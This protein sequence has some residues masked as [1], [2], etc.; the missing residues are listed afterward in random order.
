MVPDVPCPDSQTLHRFILGQTPEA[1]AQELERHLAQCSECLARAGALP[2]DD[3]LVQAMRAESGAFALADDLDPALVRKLAE[4][5]QQILLASDEDTCDDHPSAAP[6]PRPKT[7]PLPNAPREV[8]EE[9]AEFLAPP[10][11]AGELGRLGSYGIVKVLGIGGMGVVCQALQERPRRVV[12]LKIFHGGPRASRERLARFRAETEIVAQLQHANI[13]PVYE[14]GEQDGRPFF[15]MELLEGGSL[16]EQLEVRPLATQAAAQ[17]VETLARAA[18]HAHEHGFLHRDLKPSNILLTTDGVPKITDFGL[19]KAFVSVLGEEGLENR[20]E[21]GAILGTPSYMAPEQAAGRSKEVGPA[22][23]VYALGAILYEA[24]TGRPPF[25]AATILEIL[26][27]VRSQDPVAPSRLQPRLPR[28]LETVCLKCLEKDP[29]RRYGSAQA[30][31]DDLARFLRGEPIHARPSSRWERLRKWARRKPAQA[32]LLAVSG[33]SVI[34]LFAGVLVHNARLQVALGETRKQSQRA[35]TNYH[36]AREALNRILSRL[37]RKDLEGMPR[38]KELR[39]QQLEDA[40]SFYQAIL[41]GRDDPDPEGRFDAALAYAQ[42]GKIQL[43][44]GRRDAAAA[45]LQQAAALLE[46]LVAAFPEETAYPAALADCYI[47]LDYYWGAGTDGHYIKKAMALLEPLVQIQPDYARWRDL[48]AVTHHNLARI[49]QRTESYAQAE[50]HYN[51]AIALRMQLI[52]QS[53]ADTAF[54]LRLAEDYMNVG[55]VYGATGRPHEE[56][57]AYRRAEAL[58]Q[59]LVEGHPNVPEYRLTLAGVYINWGYLVGSAGR[60]EAGL[61]LHDKAVRLADAVLRQEP[62]FADAQ[63]RAL[64]AHGARAEMLEALERYADA[65]KDWERVVAVVAEP[66]RPRM[67]GNLALALARAGTHARAAVEAQALVNQP[68]ASGDSLLT[69]VRV[70]ALC[71]P[72]AAADAQLPSKERPPLAERYTLQ[73]VAILQQLRHMGYFQDPNRVKFV[74]EG[75]DFKALRTRSDFQEWLRQAQKPM[76]GGK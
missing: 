58:V 70:W 9:L 73:A 56:E 74:L 51:Q 42:T 57:A 69:A 65:A 39:Q 12:A 28:D 18:H 67:R 14:V 68:T 40:L 53:P 27:Q 33:L 38:L 15:S 13:V 6:S 54:P 23:D 50:A 55:R 24:L 30:L 17:L 59:P 47:S 45:N 72:L 5:R 37:E 16:A 52:S 11:A 2:P 41:Q 49:S 43:L 44:Q 32:A 36:E 64:E 66:E 7:A 22:A 46:D 20:T 48:L 21:S 34:G 35:D 25:Q 31:A 61:E 29:L 1:Q 19:A 71:A 26:E 63:G 62:N 4:L 8:A 3:A 76:P 75:D 60:L 10:R